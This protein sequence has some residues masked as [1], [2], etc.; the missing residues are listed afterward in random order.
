M[1]SDF[2]FKIPRRVKITIIFLLIVSAVYLL[3]RFFTP[4]IKNVPEEF[5]RARQEASLI[6]KD[7][8][9]FSG[10]TAGNIAVISELDREAKYGDALNLI[11]Q[12]LERNRQARE[13]AIE[14]SKQL[15]SM[16]KNIPEIS[17]ASAGQAALEALTSETALISRLI[18][19]NDY[20]VQLMD[21]LKKKFLFQEKNGNGRVLELINKINEE[22]RMINELDKNFNKLMDKFDNK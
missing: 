7:I 5:L 2:Y 14:L 20:L 1:I 3:A 9:D 21:I 16:I 18:S 11:S 8:I 22:A 4:E 13:K 6:A 17:P 10:Q 19:Y 15:E 12:E